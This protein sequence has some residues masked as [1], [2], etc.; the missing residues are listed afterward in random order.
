MAN[1][2]DR[3]PGSFADRLL[4]G[5]CQQY[6]KTEPQLMEEVANVLAEERDLSL[7]L[8]PCRTCS[9]ILSAEVKKLLQTIVH[10]RSKL[11]ST[12]STCTQMRT[13]TCA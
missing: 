7:R 1:N 2:F 12:K 4:A 5:L 3:Q 11:A 9:C 8:F 6:V 10:P 13:D